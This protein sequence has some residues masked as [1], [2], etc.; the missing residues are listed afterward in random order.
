MT[1]AINVEIRFTKTDKRDEVI[2]R[3]ASS[4]NIETSWKMICGKAEIILPRNVKDFDR[5]KVKEVFRKG[6]KV[7]IQLGYDGWY[8][9]EFTGYIDQVSADYPITIKLEDEMWKLKQLK[10]NFSHPNIKLKDFIQK[11]VKDYPIDID[12]DAEVMLGAVRFSQVTFGE[13]LNKLQQDFSLYSFI[14]NGKL[15]IGKPYSDVQDEVPGFDLERNCISN[16]LNYLSKEDRLVKIVGKSMQAVAKAV[17]EK[18][19]N[20]KLE[21]EFG[22]DNATDTINWTF[23]VKTLEDL[24]R[25]VKKMYNDRKKDGFD[26]SFTT[27]GIP[28][29]HHGQKVELTSTMYPDRGGVYYVD[30]VKKSI[31]NDGGYKQEI[32]LGQALTKK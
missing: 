10:V 9:I 22:D 29:V 21:F 6:D 13:V 16:D 3:K 7:E 5:Y 19:N 24:Q 1:R 31:T 11:I 14:R 17:R 32:E 25:A 30:S 4:I 15:T 26:G 27:F 2:I 23:N 8:K 20:K 12:I 28:S 18:A